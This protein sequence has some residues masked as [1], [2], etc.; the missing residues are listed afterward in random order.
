[1]RDF[2]EEI[3]KATADAVEHRGWVRLREGFNPTWYRC[4]DHDTPQKIRDFGW[5]PGEVYSSRESVAFILRDRN[6]APKVIYN[7]RRT[8]WTPGSV[9]T[10]SFKKSLEILAAETADVHENHWK[11]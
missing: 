8:Y 7:L 6:H 10:I 2:Y 11:G 9:H 5:W 4:V 1:M 3:I